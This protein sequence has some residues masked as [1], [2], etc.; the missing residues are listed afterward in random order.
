MASWCARIVLLLGVALASPVLARPLDLPPGPLADALTLE[1]E[2]GVERSEALARALVH[3]AR[4]RPRRERAALLDAACALDPAFVDAHVARARAALASGDAP[5]AATA[6]KSAWDALRLDARARARWTARAAHGLHALLA[7]ML[8]VLALLHAMRGLPLARHTLGEQLGSRTAATLLLVVPCIAALVTSLA[9]GTLV[10]LAIFASFIARRDR[11]LLAVVALALAALDWTL[12]FFAP[13]AVLLDPRTRTARIAVLN[14]GS[15]ADAEQRLKA[16]PERSAAVEL[17]LGLQA[18]R[19]GDH[20]TAHA[21]FLACLRADSTS[22]AAYV[23]LANVFFRTQQYERAAAGYRAAIALDDRDPIA[24]ANLAQT[25]IRLLQ[26]AESD[27]ELRA[28]SNLGF[29]AVAA[30]R[31]LWRDESQPVFDRTLDAAQIRALARREAAA[32][33]QVARAR[34]QGWRCGVWR[35]VRA[36]VAPGLLLAVALFLLSHLRLR[37]LASVCPDCGTLVCSHCI[38]Q[39]PEDDRCNTCQARRPHTIARFAIAESAKPASRRRMSLA[40]GRWVAALFPGAAD[41]VRGAHAS[42]FLGVGAGCAALLVAHAV[43]AAARLQSAPWMLAADAALLRAAAVTLGLVW[44]PGLLRL[45]HRDGDTV[46]VVS[47]PTAPG[48]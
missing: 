38:A 44:L 40:A 22:A 33:P 30:R 23:N 48:A 1:R 7:A 4:E 37:I 32:D 28:A 47:R 6:F 14:D 15:D 20:E 24:P 18:R 27:R 16:L 8:G 11:I 46:R 39:A 9:I 5:S 34:V 19:G 21:R 25:Y 3:T 42:A 2:R 12:P 45:R 31:A 41:L 26:Y 10:A 13:E 36:D 43:V 17:V 35:G 29:S